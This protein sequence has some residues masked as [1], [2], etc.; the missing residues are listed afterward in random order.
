M[1]NIYIFKGSRWRYSIFDDL[2]YVNKKE[3]KNCNCS[4]GVRLAIKM[5][6]GTSQLKT[7][8]ELGVIKVKLYSEE[9]LMSEVLCLALFN[10][11]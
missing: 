2:F 5:S 1:N 6:S 9:T 10:W 4:F 7:C 3:S 8:A 11:N